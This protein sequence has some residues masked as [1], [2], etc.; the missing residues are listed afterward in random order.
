MDALG[1]KAGPLLVQLPADLHRDDSRLEGFLAGLPEGVLVAVEPQHESWFD[2]AIFDLLDRHGAGFVVSV[3]AEKEPVLRTTGQLAHV[4]FT[5][6][7]RTGATADPSTTT[8]SRS[9][10]PGCA[11]SRR[12]AC[13]DSPTSTTTTTATRRS[14]GRRCARC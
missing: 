9:G 6:P 12:Q 1:D 10:R 3:I 14:T 11:N 5:T 4:R 2:D 7:I 13:R 8:L